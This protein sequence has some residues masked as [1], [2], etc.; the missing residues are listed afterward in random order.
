M[1]QQRSADWSFRVED[2][3]IV[4]EFPPGTKL[5][6]E[7]SD[8]MVERFTDLVERPE[9]DAHVTVLRSEEPYSK[10]GQENLRHSAQAGV[11][12][13]ITTWAVV[14]EGT[15]Q[16]TMRSQVDVEGVTVETF[17]LDETEAAIEWA[18]EA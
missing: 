1:S 9:T 11:E 18:R 14:A 10:E 2:N 16:L 5:S 8:K 6:G 12:H 3:V 13:G 15:K 7:E 17:D 4:A